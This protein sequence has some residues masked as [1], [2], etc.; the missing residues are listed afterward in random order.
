MPRFYNRAKI[1]QHGMEWDPRIGFTIPS[2]H[3]SLQEIVKCE[4]E[5]KGKRY[6]SLFWKQNVVTSEA[7]ITSMEAKSPTLLAGETLHLS[8]TG[9]VPYNARVAIEWVHEGKVLDATKTHFDTGNGYAGDRLLQIKNVTKKHSGVYIC[10]NKY[11]PH[12][13]KNISITVY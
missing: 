6:Y 8:C 12:V 11:F 13:A 2:P 4:T 7:K 9:E 5:V 3:H 1:D 10:R